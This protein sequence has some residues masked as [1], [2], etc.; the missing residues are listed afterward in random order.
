MVKGQAGL[1][2]ADWTEAALVALEAGGMP[3]VAVE[4][5]AKQ[6]GTTKGSF[7]WH[8]KDRADLIDAVVELW[9]RHYVTEAIAHLSTID[10]PATR[11]ERLFTVAATP[12]TGRIDL[13]LTEAAKTNPAIAETV[14]RVQ[15]RRV[16][17]LAEIYEQ[18]DVTP[19]TA[20][21]LAVLAL[22]AQAGMAV[23]AETAPDLVPTG[24][25]LD[26][27]RSLLTPPR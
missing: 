21:Q 4:P 15:T 12:G 14:R 27:L 11:L 13:A 10:D 5:L 16:E 19:G 3:A 7:Y 22:L 2:R 1:S 6:L 26:T 24:R 8:F 23:V 18:L 20:R 25:Q 9:E 17:F